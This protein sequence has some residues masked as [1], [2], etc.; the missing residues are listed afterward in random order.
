MAPFLT[1]I[2]LLNYDSDATFHSYMDP[3]PSSQNIMR[4]HAD[5]DP[6]PYFWA[7]GQD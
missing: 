4:I 3:D 6:Q 1:P 7:R 2:Q 5:L